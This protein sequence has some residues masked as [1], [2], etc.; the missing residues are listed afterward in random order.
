MPLNTIG[1]I[2]LKPGSAAEG[3]RQGFARHLRIHH[4]MKIVDGLKLSAQHRSL[5]R[6]GEMVE[7]A[8]GEFHPLPR[9]FYEIDSWE[10]AKQ[11]LLT[12]HFTISELI[13]RDKTRSTT[14]T[15]AAPVTRWP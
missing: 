14:S 4:R 15:V 12:P 11:T 2:S 6:P 3:C 10:H 1:W 7:V 5:L 9:F 13:S 8:T